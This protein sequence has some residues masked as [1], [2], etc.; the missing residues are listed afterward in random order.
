MLDFKEL[1][2][3]RKQ[4][5]KGNGIAFP[6]RVIMY[7]T[8]LCNSRCGMCNIWK[9]YLKGN[10]RKLK[11]ELSTE[12]LLQITENLITSGTK[13]IDITGGEP[14]LKEGIVELLKLIL[15]RLGFVVV[16]T[17]ALDSK[18]YIEKI[19]ETITASD[20][21]SS[22]IVYVSLDGN[23]ESHNHSRGIEESHDQT[24]KML[25]GLKK[26]RTKNTNLSIGVSYTIHKENLYEMSGVIKQLL[27]N[28][29]IENADQFAFR[30]AQ[31]N[32]FFSNQSIHSLNEKI[33]RE[34]EC[35]QKKFHF[36]ENADFIEG[37][38]ENIR[39]PQ[40]MLI[41]CQALFVSCLI[42]PY[43]EVSPCI[44][45]TNKVIGNLRN[46]SYDLLPIWESEKAAEYRKNIISDNCNICWTDCQ[47]FE[48][49]IYNQFER[50]NDTCAHIA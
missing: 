2:Y 25:T 36:H 18:S 37:I 28:H 8:N 17:N 42:G 21:N 45:M 33:L 13:H 30:P 24:M 23:K 12:E 43:G 19:R 7:I 47:A 40:K 48:N 26:L 4:R 50:E 34:I 16:I 1:E 14:F 38:K 22:L 35:V 3:T 5:I 27:Q 44:T 41:P 46:T 29:I 10:D 31:K 49:L 20:R 6:R 32:D 15:R 9:T 39:N 11:D